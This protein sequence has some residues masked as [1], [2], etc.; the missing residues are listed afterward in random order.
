MLAQIHS[1]PGF[2]E[3][4]N[5]LSHLIGAGVF[6]VFAFFLVRSARGDAGRVMFLLVFAFTSVLLLS[7]SGVYHMLREGSTGRAVLGRLDLAAIFA[8]IAGTHTPV[9]GLFFRGAARWVGLAVMWLLAATGITLFSVFY[10]SL[11]AWLGTTIYISMGWLAG[12]AGLVVW[13][14]KRAAH[15]G[16]LVGGGV[17]YSLGAVMLGLEWPTLWPGVIGPHELWHVAV[18][19]AMGLHWMFFFKNARATSSGE[20]HSTPREPLVGDR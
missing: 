15:I 3:P 20:P 5:A 19:V 1:I 6:A 11:P 12:S 13:R 16:L 4:F 17:V 9:Q 14:R 10:H 2:H 7:M 8:L 18:L